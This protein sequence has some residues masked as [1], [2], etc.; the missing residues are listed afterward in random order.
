MNTRCM[1][2]YDEGVLIPVDAMHFRLF[3]QG[4]P[5]TISPRFGSTGCLH[6]SSAVRPSPEILSM[7]MFLEVTIV[8][9]E[10]FRMRKSKNILSHIIS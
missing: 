9:I 7:S 3:R 4:R 5:A 8:A 6:G 2:M 1:M 10:H